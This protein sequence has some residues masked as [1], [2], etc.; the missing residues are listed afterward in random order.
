[1]GDLGSDMAGIVLV[2]EAYLAR[3]YRT[4]YLPMLAMRVEP[5]APKA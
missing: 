5:G 1:M 3:A 2:L 4:A